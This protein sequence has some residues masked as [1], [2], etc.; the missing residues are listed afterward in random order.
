MMGLGVAFSGFFLSHLTRA[1][2]WW[3]AIVSLLL[4]APGLKTMA[5]G[6]VL[7]LPILILQLRRRSAQAV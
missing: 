6:L 5:L 4:I 2:R 3:I 1:E 7:W